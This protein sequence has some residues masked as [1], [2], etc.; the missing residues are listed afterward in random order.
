MKQDDETTAYQLHAL[1]LSKGYSLSLRS[2][3][4][5]RTSMGWTFRGSAYC[6]L[7]RDVNKKKR[8]DW[9][10]IYIDDDFEKVIF[11]DECTVQLESHRQFCCR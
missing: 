7:I 9:A 11:I 1:L 2:V 5:C 4:Q 10:K 8:F 6:Q 3:I